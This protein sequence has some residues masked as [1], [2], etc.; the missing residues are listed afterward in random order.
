MRVRRR[1]GTAIGTKPAVESRRHGR[2]GMVRRESAYRRGGRN[3]SRG[4]GAVERLRFL[5][6]SKRRREGLGDKYLP[7]IEVL[8]GRTDADGERA[9]QVTKG[10]RSRVG[11]GGES[12]KRRNQ[13]G[14]QQSNNGTHKF[15]LPH[16]Q[17]PHTR[18]SYLC[19]IHMPHIPASYTCLTYSMP[20]HA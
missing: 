13:V 6:Q 8:P 16:I 1:Q 19:L 2:H 5:S 11:Q 14:D 4:V 15:Y 12:A 18:S 9:G 7:G 17:W 20:M 3:P 10:T